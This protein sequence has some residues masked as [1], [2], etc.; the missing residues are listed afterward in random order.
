MDNEPRVLSVPAAGRILGLG[1]SAAYDAA[2][3]GDLPTLRIGRRLVVPRARLAELL[4][5]EPWPD[6]EPPSPPEEPL[7]TD[8]LDLPTLR[9]GRRLVVPRAR[10]AEL[11]E[12]VASDGGR[13]T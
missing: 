10:L 8:P 6:P 12:E 4:G 13:A 1:R 11:L 9:L 3:R 7:D 5:E 2:R